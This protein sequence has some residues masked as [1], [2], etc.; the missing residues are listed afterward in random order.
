MPATRAGSFGHCSDVQLPR[1]RLLSSLSRCFSDLL[2]ESIPVALILSSR[3]SVSLPSAALTSGGVAA[4]VVAILREY[5]ENLWR[6]N[7]HFINRAFFNHFP[8]EIYDD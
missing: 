1:S 3:S 2:S 8:E 7:S 6:E 4:H 5:G